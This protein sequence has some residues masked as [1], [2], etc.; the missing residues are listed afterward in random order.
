MNKSAF[1][2]LVGAL[3]VSPAFAQE[4]QHGDKKEEQQTPAQKDA[5]PGK[6]ET[7]GC[8][9]DMHKAGE[10]KNSTKAKMEKMKAMKEKMAE[11][12]KAKGAEPANSKDEKV[13]EKKNE[14]ETH[15]H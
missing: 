7:K 10:T 12:M 1:L 14:K 11:K 3:S 5:V 2:I 13:G 15:E 6:T 4:H 8:C 9:E